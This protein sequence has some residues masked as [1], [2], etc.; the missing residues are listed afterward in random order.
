MPH[1]SPARGLDALQ[2]GPFLR[3]NLRGRVHGCGCAAGRWWEVSLRLR[4][5]AT[6]EERFRAKYRVDPSSGCWVW[7]GALDQCGYGSFIGNYKEKKKSAHRWSY[8]MN[9]GEIPEGLTIDHLCRNRACVNPSHLEAVTRGE[10]VRRSHR[11]APRALKTH[12]KYGHSFVETSPRSVV[13]RRAS[14]EEYSRRA[15]RACWA[16]KAKQARERKR[17]GD[18]K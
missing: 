11:D 10:N 14:G 9:V 2:G 18:Q 17:P 5:G 8:T 7:I 16:I 4:P 13:A 6:L 3:G 12:C 15:C 1:L